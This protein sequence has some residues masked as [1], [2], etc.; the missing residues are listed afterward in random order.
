MTSA[1]KAP[2]SKAGVGD[3]RIGDAAWAAC[4]CAILALQ[5]LLI[6]RHEP[7]VDEWQAL[8][9]AV[10]SP[11]LTSL[12]ANLR[13]EGHPPLW[14]V[15]LRGLAA[16][17]G[18]HAALPAASLIFGVASQ[19]LIL[20]RAPFPRW[21]RLAIA[22][23][24]P[25]LFEYGTISRSYTLGVALTFWAM[26]AWD[27]KKVIWL[28]L[29]LLPMVD[30]LFGVISLAL[31][32]LRYAERRLWWPGVAAWAAVSLLA[33]WT[34]IPAADFVPVY[35]ATA[36]PLAGAQLF[37]L[38]S[39]IVM[40]P[41]QWSAGPEWNSL[42]PHGWFLAFWIPFALLC[43][44]QTRRRPWDRIALLGFV[45][46]FLLL[47]AFSHTLANRHLMLIGIL[48][49]ALQ[50]RQ[51]LRGDPIRRF[52]RI[53][54]AIGA[55]CGVATAA[56]ALAT[57]F[58]TERQV[59]KIIDRPDLRGEHWVSAPAQHAQG[60]SA[61]S[62]ILFEG[63]GTECMNDFVR[64]NAATDRGNRLDI[65]KWVEREAKN[66]RFYLVSEFRLPPRSPA[67]QIA[68]VPPGYDG[69][70]YYVYRVGSDTEPP[71]R[72]L[73]RCVPGMI[74]LPPRKSTSS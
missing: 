74:P 6:V 73:P 33:A 68:H 2:R 23:G 42:P 48:L 61:L 56:I 47:Y 15:A 4:I 40:V 7:F 18:A 59:V 24:E 58:D 69:K 60:V 72:A 27:R 57:P 1:I 53:W 28:P 12:L 36:S 38:Q 66:G 16:L 64:W 46:V 32:L 45:A 21:L 44:D 43:F 10:Q 65:E 55:A 70:P 8:Q 34:V 50:W 29:G 35:P 14:Y 9:I 30:A 49:I 51:S 26:A 62:G 3:L 67:I 31:L 54:V 25:I 17:V 22:L 5:A 11:D 19:C 63:I 39:S 20:L 52:F 41:F 37:L 13:Y 71:R